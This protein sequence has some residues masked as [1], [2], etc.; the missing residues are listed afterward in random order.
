[1]DDSSDGVTLLS[2]NISTIMDDSSDGVTLLSINISTIMDDN[3]TV[4]M[5]SHC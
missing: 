5:V 3:E 4:V 2:I 1:M